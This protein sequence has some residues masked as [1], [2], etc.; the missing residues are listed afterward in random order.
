MEDIHPGNLGLA[1]G[2]RRLDAN[3][4]EHLDLIRVVYV[5]PNIK[6]R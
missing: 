4:L 2:G 1:G 5:Y 6:Y 3:P